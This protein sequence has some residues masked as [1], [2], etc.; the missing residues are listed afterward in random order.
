MQHHVPA[1]QEQHG[2]NSIVSLM[3]YGRHADRTEANSARRRDQQTA[4]QRRVAQLLGRNSMKFGG[5]MG[6]GVVQN[7]VGASLMLRMLVVAD[8]RV[9][10]SA[11]ASARD[12]PARLRA[13][14]SAPA[15]KRPSSAR[16]SPQ[17]L[18]RRP[19]RRRAAA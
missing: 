16:R 11:E 9:V 8:P 7:D 5:E 1:V 2:R 18:E 12:W 10:V 13:V 6:I 19:T 15:S 17:P 14:R 4:E 3:S